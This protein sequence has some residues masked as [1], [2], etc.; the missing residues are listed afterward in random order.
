MTLVEAEAGVVVIAI[1]GTSLTVLSPDA[2]LVLAWKLMQAAGT[3][4]RQ[5]GEHERVCDGCGAE[6]GRGCVCNK[7]ASDVRS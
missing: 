2:A 6:S 3:A 1:D 7:E 5:R 4:R